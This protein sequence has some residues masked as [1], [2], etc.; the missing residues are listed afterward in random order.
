MGQNEEDIKKILKFY[1]EE[2]ER[3]KS[4]ATPGLQK[5]MDEE[6]APYRKKLDALYDIYMFQNYLIDN[7][8][9]FFN[10]PAN[11]TLSLFFIKASG[12]LFAIRQ[13]L[14]VGQL[15]SASS[16]ERN[17]FETYIDTRLIIEK[18]T[19][20]RSNLYENY[21]HVL[22]W[23]RIKTYKKYLEELDFDTD[24]PEEVKKSEKIYYE[25]L[26]K[27][28]NEDAA[29]KNY[30]DVKNNY[31]PKYPYHWAWKIFK[32]EI[33]D[34]RN[35]NREFLCKK[36]GIYNDY[37]HVYSTNSLAVHNQPFMANFMTRKG[38]E[39]ITSVPVFSETTASIAGIS[40]SLVIEIIMMILEYS[41]MR[42]NYEK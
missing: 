27:D 35:P 36:L 41:G 39:G 31:H 3:Y 2:L 33:K 16:I 28:I 20:E 18:D 7:F 24:I 23:D 26:Y 17:I 19:E 37:L 13:C 6:R 30:E 42:I 10:N 5:L 25:N 14:M 8:Q 29:M 4:I 22:L 32:D 11:K 21:Q 40:A 1:R 9:E 12:D 34:Q 15:I 38:R